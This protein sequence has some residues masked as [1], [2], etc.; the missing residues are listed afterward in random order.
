M[1]RW[2]VERWTGIVVALL[3]ASS[4]LPGLIGAVELLV[5]W[6][7]WAGSFA[8]VFATM[9]VLWRVENRRVQQALYAVVMLLSWLVVL[10]APEA[11]LRGTSTLLVAVAATGLFVLGLPLSLLVIVLNTIVGLLAV[12]MTVP[13]SLQRIGIG[14]LILLIQL[15]VVLVCHM[16]QR[17]HRL[18]AELAEAYVGRRAA[19]AILSETA[20][21]AERLHIA[22][23][24]H[25]VLGHQLTLLNLKLEAAKYQRGAAPDTHLE[26]A[27]SVA[28]SLLG[29]VR[30]TVSDL[31]TSQV[32]TLAEALR[33]LGENITNLE[34]TV[35]VSGDLNIDE[36]QQI[37]LLR[38][39]QEIVTNTIRHAGARELS[40]LIEGDTEGIVLAAGDDGIG[41]LPVVPGNGLRGLTERFAQVSGSIEFAGENGFQVRAWMPTR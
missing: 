30:T 13:D 22:R 20:R 39:V 35:E 18:R 40:I 16:F 5:P 4:G 24:L 21:S 23:E 1:R 31:R 26:D 25:D 8:A 17:E 38:S 37:V 41:A 12:G 11:T 15:S 34:V 36:E 9:L 29:D 14:S 6:P 27:Q 10:T 19:E 3:V 7:L 2:D 28:R 33:D 32:S